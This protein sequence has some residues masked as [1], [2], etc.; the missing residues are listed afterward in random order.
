[1]KILGVEPT[2]LNECNQIILDSISIFWRGQR[3]PIFGDISKIS[4]EKKTLVQMTSGA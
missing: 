2:T 3:K 4:E 1:M